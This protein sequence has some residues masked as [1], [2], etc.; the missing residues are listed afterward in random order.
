MIGERS[1]ENILSAEVKDINAVK[2]ALKQAFTSL[3]RCDSTVIIDQVTSLTNRLL[4]G[5]SG[6]ECK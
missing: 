1:V 3:M 6:L 5:G 2:S 4:A